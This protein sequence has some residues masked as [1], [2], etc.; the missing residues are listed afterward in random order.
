M[1]A[2]NYRNAKPRQTVEGQGRVSRYAWGDADYHDLI[3]A[4][5]HVLGNY[6]STMEPAAKVRGVVDTAP[7]LERDFA[8]LAGLGWIGKNTLLL[9]RQHGSWFFL[10]ALL[11]DLTLAYDA[12]QSTD[13]CGTC[14]A[15]LDACPTSAFPAPYVLNASRC[16]SYLTIELR[17]AIPHQL[18]AGLGDWVFGCDV[19]QDVCPWNSKAPVSTQAEFSPRPENDPVD[20]IA[21]FELDDAAFRTRFLNTPLWRPRRRGLL[22]NAAIALGNRPTP[23]AIPALVRGLNDDEPLVR[24]ACAWALGRHHTIAAC[25]A[26]AARQIIESDAEVSSEIALALGTPIDSASP[27]EAESIS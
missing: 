26:L 9:N 17:G 14:R 1:L 5:L 8:Q 15:C 18:R 20:L 12:A 27:G 4:S 6:I 25:E 23:A 10:A 16:I 2:M 3:R 11:T 21:L 13:H 7:F 24:G 19:C 22:R